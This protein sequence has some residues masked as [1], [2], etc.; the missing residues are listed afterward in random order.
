M[1]LLGLVSRVSPVHTAVR[2]CT[3]DEGGPFG[4]GN[5]LLIASH[6][7]LLWKKATGFRSRQFDV[8]H[9]LTA[10]RQKIGHLCKGYFSFLRLKSRAARPLLYQRKYPVKRKAPRRKA[11][12]LSSQRCFVAS[13]EVQ[14]AVILSGRSVHYQHRRCSS[15]MR[16]ESNYVVHSEA[17]PKLS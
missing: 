14:R 9:P 2:N 16:W 3:R 1:S 12:G 5:Q 15:S 17:D 10:P 13:Y 6:R 8:R 11:A 7:K 4:I